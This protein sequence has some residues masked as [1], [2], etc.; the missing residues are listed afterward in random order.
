MTSSNSSFF[1]RI[2]RGN[3]SLLPLHTDNRRSSS[4]SSNEYDLRDLSPRI[5]SPLLSPDTRQDLD[6]SDTESRSSRRSFRD[7]R[8]KAKAVAY[9]EHAQEFPPMSVIDRMRLQREARA[10]AQAKLQQQQ[11]QQLSREQRRRQGLPSWTPPFTSR[12]PDENESLPPQEHGRS[13]RTHNT[14]LPSPNHQNYTSSMGFVGSVLLG[15]APNASDRSTTVETDT[16]FRTLQRRERQIQ[17]ELQR[18]LDAQGAAIER[19]ISWDITTA[20]AG[21]ESSRASTPQQG[22]TS[23]RS[24]A[25]QS[26]MRTRNSAGPAVIP[27]RQ[28]KP[29]PLSLDEVREGIARALSMLSDLK[30]EETQYILES[31]Q[32]RLAAIAKA[33]KLANQHKTIASELKAMETDTDSPLQR[34][35]KSMDSEYKHVCVDIEEFEQ[36]LRLLKQR[37]TELE[38]RMEEARSERESGLSGYRGALKGTERSIGDMMKRPGVRV[39]D[40]DDGL[41]DS[42]SQVPGEVDHKDDDTETD[43]ES[44]K[45]SAG[46]VERRLTGKDFM[47]L[48]PERRTLAMAKEWWLGEIALL[49]QRQAAV[50]REVKALHEGIE[51][52]GDVVGEISGYEMRLVDAITN[53]MDAN[54]EDKNMSLKESL[55]RRDEKLF[56]SQYSDLTHTIRGIEGYL[57]HAEAKGYNLLIA[58][59]GGELTGFKEGERMLLET[60]D[61]HGI[62]YI[63]EDNK[64]TTASTT[65]ERG[66]GSRVTSKSGLID[67]Q[68]EVDRDRNSRIPTLHDDETVQSEK[69]QQLSPLDDDITGSVIRNWGGSVLEEQQQPEPTTTKEAP[70]KPVILLSRSSRGSSLVNSPL[71]RSLHQEAK[72]KFEDDHD[73]NDDDHMQ[74]HSQQ[75]HHHHDESDNEVP[76]GLLSESHLHD[77]EESDD[78]HGHDHDSSTNEVPTEF[79]SMYHDDDKDEDKKASPAAV[80]ADAKDS[81]KKD[82][83]KEKGDEEEEHAGHNEVPLDL[84]TESR[85]EDADEHT[86]HHNEVPLDLMTESRREDVD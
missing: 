62:E 37:K 42:S 22:S 7:R 32:A 81:S 48:R 27:V 16:T 11:Q 13:W 40:I 52:W 23:R 84:M 76:L 25:S 24:S 75:E 79:L 3:E 78:G 14:S 2:A 17:E 46:L 70:Q 63:K 33:N 74:Q 59:I 58:A 36:K 34:E 31:R 8:S 80:A 47:H 77:A 61:S 55:R 12:F 35:I 51:V 69:Q 18:L 10:A 86:D 45:E 66:G 44:V 82:S 26:P 72:V 21:D 57:G 1:S 38:R 56:R 28:P 30:A 65:K 49:T 6:F 68:Q 83:G 19:Q 41:L 60:M 73:H 71:K 15:R 20:A 39:L 4:R 43:E 9:A 29:K 53:L 67:L 85:K 50:D 64:K 54:L 5:S